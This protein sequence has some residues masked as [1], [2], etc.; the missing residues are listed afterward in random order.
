[1]HCSP[2]V[3]CSSSQAAAAVCLRSEVCSDNLSRS[4]YLQRTQLRKLSI[5]D[6]IAARVGRGARKNN[7]LV[8]N[9]TPF[10]F[11]REGGGEG[12]KREERSVSLFWSFPPFC[13]AYRCHWNQHL[14]CQWLPGKLPDIKGKCT[15]PAVCVW[16]EGL[17]FWVCEYVWQGVT[18]MPGPKGIRQEAKIAP[19]SLPL[20]S[21]MG[22]LLKGFR[23]FPAQREPVKTGAGFVF[24]D[25][26]TRHCEIIWAWLNLLSSQTKR[27]L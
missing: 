11:S 20:R 21:R 25:P 23:F 5:A 8:T 18:V 16:M 2:D 17:C 14:P 27:S 1:M 12:E 13:F 22:F 19:C 3:N 26:I 7:S 15:G 10:S 4:N 9:L 6:A 24:R